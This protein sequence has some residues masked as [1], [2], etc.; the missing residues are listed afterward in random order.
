M[1]DVVMNV[2]FWTSRVSLVTEY[3]PV[4]TKPDS[5]NLQDNLNLKFF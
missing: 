5:I 3:V 4:Y 2:N 1:F